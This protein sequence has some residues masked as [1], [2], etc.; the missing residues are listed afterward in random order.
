LL[1]VPSILFGALFSLALAWML[2]NICLQGL[3]S[4]RTVILAIGAAAESLLIFLL[5]LAGAANRATFILAGVALCLAFLRLQRRPA[6]F[7]D[8]T[9][10]PADRLTFWLSAAAFGGYGIF[11][12]MNAMAPELQPDA[13]G[14]HLGLVSEYV[15]LGRF[16]GRV[17]FYNVMPQGLEMLFVPAFAFGRHSAA[18]LVHFAFLLATLP[19]MLRIGRR[20]L[21]PDTVA[22]AAAALYFCSPV[23]G[24][25]GSSAYNDAALVFFVLV[26]FYLLL[27]WQ[28]TYDVRYLG[29]AGITAGYCYAIKMPGIVVL[30]LALVFVSTQA[31][32]DRRKSM[33]SVLSAALL[34]IAPWMLRATLMTGN[35]GAPLF[36]WIFPNG[37]FH[38]HIE[39]ELASGMGSLQ[40]I[41]PW[42]IPYELAAGGRLQGILGPP[43]LAAPLALLALRRRAGRLCLTAAVLLAVPWFWNA[44]TRFLM[45]SL[46]LLALALITALPRPAVWVCMA[47]QAAGCW[48]QVIDLYDAQHIWRLHDMPVRAALRIEPEDHYLWRK[49][50]DYKIAHILEHDT[51][52]GERIFALISV[53]TAYTDRDVVQ[54]WHSASAQQLNEGLR[55]VSIYR[56]EPF[57]EVRAHWPPRPLWGVRI[58]VAASNPASWCI[59][60]VKL[61]S[62]DYRIFNS[63]QWRLRARPNVWEAPL[64]F[65]ENTATCWR[66]WVPVRAGMY[67]EATF[68]RAQ[69]LSTAVITSHTP[70][71]D[72]PFEFYGRGRDGW[73]LITAK[74]EVA[75]ISLPDLREAATQA[76]RNAGFKYI[77]AERGPEGNGLLGAAF[78]G[79]EAEWGLQKAGYAGRVTLYRIR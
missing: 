61:Y 65:D 16:P 52:P 11:Y 37:Y 4:P 27:L 13:A 46:P 66:T 1:I 30:P 74:P 68:D 77:L 8:F 57:F 15:R 2:G 29:P 36:N 44:G 62:G 45:P 24:V 19:L 28:D 42:A 23:V 64:A 20:L 32:T 26:T 75:R 72:L 34:M 60:D 41:R 18:K 53:A 71:H 79:H 63:P 6:H 10:A 35:P 67:V 14:Y 51:R 55:T 43:F 12:L 56:A 49:L 39:K 9:K 7:E 78:A 40:G 38:A 54:F 3:P 69:V 25:S 47:L 17:G 22:V 33:I 48:P 50:D 76:I 31:A 21:L 58:R 70:R 73:Q 5:L 59:H